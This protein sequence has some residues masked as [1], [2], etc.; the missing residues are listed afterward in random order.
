LLDPDTAFPVGIVLTELITNA[1]KYAFPNG[2]S[3]VVLAQAQRTG[4]RTVELL[5]RDDG[6]G[7]GQVREGS[8]GYGLVRSLV[9]Q[10]RGNIA[11]EG[12]AGVAVRITFENPAA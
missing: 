3:G 1:L 2:R 9:N 6:V 12:G 10:I 5:V 4:G 8:L 7:M 11:V